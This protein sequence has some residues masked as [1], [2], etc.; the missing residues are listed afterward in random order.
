MGKGRQVI[1]GAFRNTGNVVAMEGSAAEGTVWSVTPVS[2]AHLPS[3]PSVVPRGPQL[4][5]L[6]ASAMAMGACTV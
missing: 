1:E 2:P 3:R 4:V 5:T 6:V